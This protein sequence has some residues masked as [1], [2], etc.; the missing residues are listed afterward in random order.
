[1][2]HRS[3]IIVICISFFLNSVNN[4]FEKECFTIFVNS[5]YSRGALRKEANKFYVIFNHIED[6]HYFSKK[7]RCKDKSLCLKKTK[8]I[9]KADLLTVISI[10]KVGIDKISI[11]F[12]SHS[13]GATYDGT[14]FLGIVNNR[15]IFLDASYVT[16]IE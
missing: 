6:E 9:N 11:K 4:E 15:P 16:S 5:L 14:V 1:M 10:T 12:V 8:S 13:G 2:I 3:F 7:V